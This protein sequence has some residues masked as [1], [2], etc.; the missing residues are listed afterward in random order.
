MVALLISECF[1]RVSL[2]RSVCTFTQTVSLMLNAQGR[3][4]HSPTR[5]K[6]TPPPQW[7]RRVSTQ[8]IPIAV[9]D[10]QN[11][12]ITVTQSNSTAYICEVLRGTSITIQIIQSVRLVLCFTHSYKKFTHFQRILSPLNPSH[13][14]CN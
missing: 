4:A 11:S 3:I 12:V 6:E 9:L 1:P 10:C 2:E 5:V 13:W 8:I 14:L 7:Y